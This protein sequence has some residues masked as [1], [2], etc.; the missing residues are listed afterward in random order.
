VGVR[1]G[2]VVCATC[3]EKMHEDLQYVLNYLE[4]SHN[5]I[6]GITR[7]IEELEE[8]LKNIKVQIKI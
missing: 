4:A 2:F 6:I 3:K 5:H 8:R 7:H 1:L